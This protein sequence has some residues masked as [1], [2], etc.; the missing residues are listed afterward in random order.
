MLQHLLNTGIDYMS[1]HIRVK[2]GEKR[3][4]YKE[5]PERR[6]RRYTEQNRKRSLKRREDRTRRIEQAVQESL[7]GYYDDKPKFH[8]RKEVIEL[9]TAC[10]ITIGVW[11]VIEHMVKRKH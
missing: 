2:H 10:L 9:C 4:R 11:I 8:T 5:G 6:K 7:K 3:K 1:R